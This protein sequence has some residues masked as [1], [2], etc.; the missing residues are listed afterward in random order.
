M[1]DRNKRGESRPRDGCG[2]DNPVGSPRLATRTAQ[3]ALGSTVRDDPST[4][5]LKGRRYQLID[6]GISACYLQLDRYVGSLGISFAGENGSKGGTLVDERFIVSRNE[7]GNFRFRLSIR[8]S[9][10]IVRKM[11]FYADRELGATNAPTATVS[12][13]YCPSALS[14]CLSEYASEGKS[15]FIGDLFR[16]Q[17]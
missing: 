5:P 7:L 8:E 9:Y 15:P 14:Q 4:P 12:S 3:S 16:E 10:L 13:Y 17:K 2:S 1:K 11:D 6:F